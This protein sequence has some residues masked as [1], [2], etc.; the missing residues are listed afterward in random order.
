MAEKEQ[1]K[2]LSALISL[3][4][5]PDREVY[6]AVYTKLLSFGPK[7]IPALESY[8]EESFDPNL[9]ER[10]ELIIHQIQFTNLKNELTDWIENHSDDLFTG[11]FLAARY[12]Y[13]DLDKEG[14]RADVDEIKRAIWLELNYGLTPLEQVNVFNHVFYQLLGFAGKTSNNP[15]AL[16]FYINNLLESKKGNA[17]S[18]GTLYLILAQDLDI[19]IYGVNL[20]RHFVLA[21]TKD[22]I[23][24]LDEQ[25]DLR[26]QVVFYINP[27]N[28]G[29]IFTRNEILLFLKKLD[30][31]PTNEHFTP[32]RNLQVVKILLENLAQAYEEEGAMEKVKEVQELLQ[33]FV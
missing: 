31:E 20:P 33:L 2:E 23:E 1:D 12:Q 5:D 19:P 16:T 22:F 17:M 6:D 8:W 29:T 28:K 10:I 25:T 18:L 9:Q 30:L 14:I 24:T 26:D 13:A 27:L 15:G 3:L 21:Y 4:D 7:V 11:A 32:C